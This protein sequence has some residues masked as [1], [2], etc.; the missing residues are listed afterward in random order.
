MEL[1]TQ[2]LTKQQNKLTHQEY[3]SIER[4]REEKY[5]FLNNKQI[6]MGGASYKH[7]RICNNLSFFLTQ[8][9]EDLSYEVSQSDLRVSIPVKNIYVYPDIVVNTTNPQFIDDKFDTLLDPILLIEV[10]SPSTES[11]DRGEKSRNFR[12]I[13]S[14]KEYV[15]ISQ[16]QYSV[17]S[18][19]RNENGVWE[20]TESNNFDEKIKFRSIDVEVPL[21][22]IYKNLK[23]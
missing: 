14:L 5:E 6:I 4:K 23:N 9:A 20:L 8:F 21:K 13:D 12:L 22:Q 16:E 17:E 1:K 3:L 2:Q 18:Y 19:F 11:R 10:L 15:I 7:N